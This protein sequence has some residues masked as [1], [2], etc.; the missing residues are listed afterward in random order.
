MREDGALRAHRFRENFEKRVV[1]QRGDTRIGPLLTAVLKDHAQK[2]VVFEAELSNGGSR[3]HFAPFAFDGFAASGVQIAERHRRDS[4]HISF[5]ILQE[6]FP[7]HIYAVMSVR[8]DKLFVE[9]AYQNDVPKSPNCGIR[10]AICL[11]PFTH[12]SSSGISGLTARAGD[13]QERLR[14]TSF[15]PISQCAK[16]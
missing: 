16:A 3:A 10:L 11:E 9:S 8:E 7:E 5:T 13:A 12:G 4:E 2:F 1:G 15:V 14:H 6:G